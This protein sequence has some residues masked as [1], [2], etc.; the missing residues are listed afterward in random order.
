MF[1]VRYVVCMIC[2]LCLLFPLSTSFGSSYDYIKLENRQIWSLDQFATKLAQ[3]HGMRLLLSGTGSLVDAESTRRGFSFIDDRLATV[4]QARP[5][6]ISMLKGFWQKLNGDPLFKTWMLLDD[7]KRTF[8]D[9]A[10]AMKVSYW[11]QNN[12]RPLAPL[13]SQVRV[14]EDKISY[15]TASPKNQSLQLVHSESIAEAL[16][17]VSDCPPSRN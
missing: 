15:F 1:F 17:I 3:Q 11:D 14:A 7:E 4:E 16:K 12:D 9:Y 8:F 5:M 10:F 2:S 13:L 6:V